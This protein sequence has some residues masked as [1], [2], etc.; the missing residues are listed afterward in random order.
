VI[1]AFSRKVLTHMLRFNIKKGDVVV[2]LSLLL[3]EYKIEGITLRNDNGSQFIAGVVRQFLKEKGVNQ[4]FTHVAT[5]QE[6]AYIEA[7]HSNVQREVVERYEFDSIYHAQMIFNRYYDWYNNNR[8]HGSLGR[9]SPEKFLREN[10]LKSKSY[11]N[12]KTTDIV[13]NFNPILSKN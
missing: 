6:N 11:K 4:E 1:D 3:M 2:L 8:K 13:S 9:K 10:E 12:Q 7:L 5:P